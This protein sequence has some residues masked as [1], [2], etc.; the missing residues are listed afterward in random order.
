MRNILF[1]GHIFHQKP[2]NL[3]FLRSFCLPQNNQRSSA[4]FKL[5]ESQSDKA[6]FVHFHRKQTGK[7]KL[8]KLL[9]SFLLLNSYFLKY[10]HVKIDKFFL[11][12][13]ALCLAKVFK[14]Q[15]LL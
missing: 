8:R 5:P 6:T 1:I 9:M 3:Y 12:D 10:D 7:E 4:S 13:A 2:L 14:A 15:N 11:P